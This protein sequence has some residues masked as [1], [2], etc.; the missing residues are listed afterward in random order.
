MN[1]LL[2]LYL[3]NNQT[4]QDIPMQSVHAES[5]KKRM[6]AITVWRLSGLAIL[7]MNAIKA[8]NFY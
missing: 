1:C 5:I 7:A 2:S 3:Q 8:Q 6:A 4:H